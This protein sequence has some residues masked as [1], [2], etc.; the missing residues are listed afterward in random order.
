LANHNDATTSDSYGKVTGTPVRIWK[1]DSWRC[2][3]STISWP[4]G[5]AC[6]HS[7]VREG[8]EERRIDLLENIV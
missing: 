2:E 3:H 7:W 1:P 6:K 8:K 5:P 4:S